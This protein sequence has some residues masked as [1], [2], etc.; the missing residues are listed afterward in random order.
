M[1]G[2]LFI[3]SEGI[4]IP[5]LSF[6]QIRIHNFSKLATGGSY[7]IAHGIVS[8]HC[9]VFSDTYSFRFSPFV[10]G[11]RNCPLNI[12]ESAVGDGG[13]FLGYSPLFENL[14]GSFIDV[15]FVRTAYGYHFSRINC[16]PLEMKLRTS[17][18][19]AYI[20]EQT[21]E[22]AEQEQTRTVEQN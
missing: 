18:S 5:V 16:L 2:N 10:A 7:W 11:V 15:L 19:Y 14:D 21:E 12:T 17:L 3:T 1:Q 20:F 13:F 8:R 9:V 22:D 4:D 6:Y